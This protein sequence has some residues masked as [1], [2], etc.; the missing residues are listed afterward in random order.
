MQSA[1]WYFHSSPNYGEDVFVFIPLLCDAGKGNY[2][3]IVIYYGNLDISTCL[4][5][6]GVSS[7]E[8]VPSPTILT[9]LTGEVNSP[10]PP[11]VDI[12]QECLWL[13]NP[14]QPNEYLI[15]L[16]FNNFSLPTQS[17]GQ[18]NE[19]ITFWFSGKCLFPD[20]LLLSRRINF[21]RLRGSCD[22]ENGILNIVIL[23]LSLI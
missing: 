21:S 9:N 13:F 15:T 19:Q 12:L 17:N 18:C 2:N 4:V 22:C 6:T 16:R 10:R 11:K 1:E 23:P 8:G 5:S 20:M 14:P 3:L 7:C